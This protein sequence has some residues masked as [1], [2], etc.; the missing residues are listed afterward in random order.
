M[1]R[2]LGSRRSGSQAPALFEALESRQLMFSG[3]MLTSPL[4]A[5]LL[6]DG[7]DTVVRINTNLGNIDIELFD[8]RPSAATAISNF[9]QYITNGRYDETFFDSLVPGVSLGGGSYRFSTTGGL[10]SVPGFS[11]IPATF[12][13]ANLA[14]TVAFQPAT[15]TTAISRFVINLQD[16]PAFNTNYVVFGKVVQGWD[17]VTA[18]AGLGRQDLDA[19]FTPGN[20]TGT[21]FNNVPVTPDFNGG[22]GATDFTLVRLNDIEVIKNPG[23]TAYFQY[24][25]IYPEGKRGAN[26]IEF[27]DLGNMGDA[28]NQVQ[29]LVRYETGDRDG[30]AFNGTLPI[31]QRTRLTM[32]HFQSSTL[33]LVRAGVPYTI[34]VRS[35]LP[36]AASITRREGVGSSGEGAFTP[37]PANLPTNAMTAWHFAAGDKGP[38]NLASVRWVGL[39]DQPQTINVEIYPEGVA[40]PITASYA[41]NPFRAG[42][43]AAD[44]LVTGLADGTR[45]SVRV[46]STQPFVAALTREKLNGNGIGVDDMDAA[47]GAL[48][49]GRPRGFLAGARLPSAAG[50]EAHV[51]FFY[52]NPNVSFVNVQLTFFLNNGTTV[53]TSVNLS[54][55]NRRARLDLTQ[56]AGLPRNQYFSIRY[57]ATG[58]VNVAAMYTANAGFDQLATPFTTATTGT[59]LIGDGFYNPAQPAGTIGEAISLFNPFSRSDGAQFYQLLFRFSD[60]TQIA[61]PSG[62]GGTLN[63]LQ[64]TDI[65]VT[66]IPDVMAKINLSPTF[67]FYSIKV[68]S[69][70]QSFNVTA[71]A[72]IAQ[73]TRIWN[74]FGQGL[75][76][77][78]SMSPD[79]PVVFTND[80]TQLDGV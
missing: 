7:N 76:S 15:L 27:L 28:T 42:G 56:V 61:Y 18:I 78:A 23:Q 36:I 20:P 48:A 29:V 60:G 39:N 68:I 6:T 74:N 50:T 71:D 72:I 52:S 67:R 1:K 35:T 53:N 9:R 64:R 51:D 49:G 58:N 69:A 3:P 8:N 31:A 45:Y 43:V 25:T 37:T 26:I 24:S 11:P 46:F 34:E 66:D 10:T 16:N 47:L 57:Q 40:T 80:T 17:V 59:V 55:A 2:T 77:G 14:R 79:L 75:T 63:P 38:L 33:N 62:I 12:T 54:A 73:Y 41:L 32:S 22:V 44:T 13:T 19:Q 21:T 5:A 4:S 65:R 30:I 70:S